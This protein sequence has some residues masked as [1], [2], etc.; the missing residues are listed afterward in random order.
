[1]IA[2]IT[3]TLPPRSIDPAARAGV[4]DGWM[5]ARYSESHIYNR[6]AVPL[7]R[8]SLALLFIAVLVATVACSGNALSGRATST[9]EPEPSPTAT[10]AVDLNRVFHNF[11]YPLRGACWP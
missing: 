6:K 8:F 2:V 9:T 1:M 4:T 5:L 11:I 3:V 10:A 7:R